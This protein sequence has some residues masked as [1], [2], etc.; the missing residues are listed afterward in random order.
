MDHY[1]YRC[2]VLKFCFYCLEPT[3]P[4]LD[5]TLMDTDPAMLSVTYRSPEP[6]LRNGD[7]TGYMIRYSRVGSGVLEMMSIGSGNPNGF[8]TSVI[9]GLVAFINY[10]VE[11]AA[12]NVNGT[13]PYSDIV[14]GVSGQ[15]SM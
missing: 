4:P 14:F 6:S 2:E 13:G 11:V 10:S 3:G 5:I 15:D 1:N 8:R 9:P 7:V 12:A